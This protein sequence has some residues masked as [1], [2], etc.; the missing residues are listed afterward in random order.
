MRKSAVFIGLPIAALMLS[1][2]SA[3]SES[4]TTLFAREK[5]ERKIQELAVTSV[6]AA[7]EAEESNEGSAEDGLTKHLLNEATNA[8]SG[9][10]ESIVPGTEISIIGQDNG[11]PEYSIS[12]IQQ[13][14]AETDSSGTVFWQGQVSNHDVTG[15]R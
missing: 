15:L 7:A 11:K 2:C 1:G 12:T 4:L 9:W 10:A 6:K 8:V 5:D 13:I 14:G 3:I